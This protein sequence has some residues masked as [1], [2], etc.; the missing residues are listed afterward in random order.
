MLREKLF[1]SLKEG[2]TW[3]DDHVLAHRHASH[4]ESMGVKPDG[5]KWSAGSG[6]GSVGLIEKPRHSGEFGNKSAPG[7][8]YNIRLPSDPRRRPTVQYH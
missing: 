3:T 2:N 8:S 5:E 4:Y 1:K 6:S 7:N